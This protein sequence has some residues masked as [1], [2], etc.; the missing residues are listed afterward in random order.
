MKRLILFPLLVLLAGCSGGAYLS[1]STAAVLSSIAIDPATSS[2]AAGLT[3]AYTA[4]GTFSD[5]TTQDV[6]SQASWS[7]S[8][9]AVATV[10]SSGVAT[11]VA[12]G[13]S[14]IKASLG[15]ISGNSSLTVTPAP[16]GTLVSISV[17]PAT[18]SIAV[19]AKQQFTATGNYS[20]G[21]TQ[22]LTSSVT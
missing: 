18:A 3:V 10:S 21:T 6:T 22:N 11:A 9:T 1:P 17:A 2:V 13:T 20:D 7:S 16:T 5:G 15:S 4:T 12:P 14:T 8:S 19:G